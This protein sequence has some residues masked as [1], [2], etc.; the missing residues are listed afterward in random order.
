MGAIIENDPIITKAIND[1]FQDDD[2][3][4][5]EKA[6]FIY[7]A[8]AQSMMNAADGK[9]MEWIYGA[10]VHGLEKKAVEDL[11]QLAALSLKADRLMQLNSYVLEH[12]VNRQ[13][14]Q[15]L[16]EIA[17]EEVIS[18]YAPIATF[19]MES[20]DCNIDYAMES[21]S[22]AVV[23]AFM[24]T[25][26]MIIKIIAAILVAVIAIIKFVMSSS[27]ESG[28][29]QIAADPSKKNELEEKLNELETTVAAK[30]TTVNYKSKSQQ[31]LA[32][33]KA[34]FNTELDKRLMAGNIPELSAEAIVG[35]IEAWLSYID[36]VVRLF[37]DALVFII[38]PM[39]DDNL[40][41]NEITSKLSNAEKFFNTT[42]LKAVIGP[43]FAPVKYM[44][45]G[46][47]GVENYVASGFSADKLSHDSVL[48]DAFNKAFNGEKDI[49]VKIEGPDFWTIRLQGSN[50]EYLTPPSVDKSIY[51]TGIDK[52]DTTWDF[53]PTTLDHQD[54]DRVSRQR[55][56]QK[57]KMRKL[58]SDFD[59]VKRDL[60]KIS[61]Q[62]NASRRKRLTL[63]SRQDNGVDANAIVWPP[64][65]SGKRRSEVE[66]KSYNG[67][68]FPFVM[69][70]TAGGF[71]MRFTEC[72][73]YGKNMMTG[74]VE[75]L[76][77]KQLLM[78]EVD[79]YYRLV[80]EDIAA[81]E[82]LKK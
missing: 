58:E 79:R 10:V 2:R 69:V 33:L 14:M 48:K 68:D 6:E 23:G 36:D 43:R 24:A 77:H 13:V 9:P 21:F 17:G 20:S 40:S 42:F 44:S 29:S 37:G 56:I 38:K 66:G 54:P 62:A 28:S 41:P 25:H 16:V 81:L 8:T 12:G 47:P 50:G 1:A 32:F 75:L 15:A 67:L 31:A 30:N 59:T 80:A 72:L 60:K 71:Y 34:R 39:L 46:T 52:V 19:T 45:A 73:S 82:K 78:K 22:L 57:G 3:S 64:E 51:L 7:D 26:A 55:S 35:T 65:S 53:D 5:S 70:S 76:K 11:D 27:E 74:A 4:I 63:S 49:P 18:E 61:D